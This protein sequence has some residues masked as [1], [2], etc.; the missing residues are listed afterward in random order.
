MTHQ[1]TP[2]RMPKYTAMAAQSSVVIADPAKAS[3]GCNS[4]AVI[5]NADQYGIGL[6]L[7]SSGSGRLP[8]AARQTPPRS[9]SPHITWLMSGVRSRPRVHASTL[10]RYGNI[11]EPDFLM[12]PKKVQDPNAAPLSIFCQTVR[13]PAPFLI[14]GHR[15][16]TKKRHFTSKNTAF[17]EGINPVL[18]CIM[19]Q[20]NGMHIGDMSPIAV[21]PVLVTGRGHRIHPYCHRR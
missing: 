19:L 16:G 3:V 15:F 14:A 4:C 2:S 8:P 10:E 17:H 12:I 9:P 20:M 21:S 5:W 1:A 6:A 11:D 18:R 7:G 13:L